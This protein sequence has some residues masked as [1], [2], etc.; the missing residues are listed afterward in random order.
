MD[1]GKLQFMKNGNR[2][3]EA[4]AHG[5]ADQSTGLPKSWFITEDFYGTL[6]DKTLLK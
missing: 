5:G 2:I 4:G 6:Q 3:T 1:S